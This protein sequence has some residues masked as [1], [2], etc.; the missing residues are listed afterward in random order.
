MNPTDPKGTMTRGWDEM[1]NAPSRMGTMPG[2]WRAPSIS[3]PNPIDVGEQFGNA[4]QQ[5]PQQMQ[6]F[7]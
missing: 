2:G 1:M 3:V 5:I 7:R 6:N 4:A